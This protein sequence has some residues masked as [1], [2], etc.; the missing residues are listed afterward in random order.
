[1]ITLSHPTGNANVRAIAASL[2]RA[3]L[4]ESFHTSIATFPGNGWDKLSK[5]PGMGDIG[6]REFSA[7][8]APLTKQ[9]P[10]REVG[11]MVAGKTGIASLTAHEH[12]AF[13]VDKVY[14][15]LDEEVAKAIT[16]GRNI[17]GVYAYEDGALATFRAAK[18]VGLRC[19]YDLPIAY[20]QT[21]GK[22]MEEEAARYP[23]WAPTLSGGDGDS[24]AKLNRKTQELELADAVVGPGSFV[25][26]SLPDWAA[27]IHRIVAPFG[28]PD[29]PPPSAAQRTPAAGRRLRVLFAGSLTQRKGLA[30]LFAAMRL[31]DGSQVE[32]IVLGGLRL[33]L[34]FYKTEFG[35]FTYAPN[36]SAR[37]STGVNGKLRRFLSAFYCR[38]PRPGH[39]GGDESGATRHHHP[40]HGRCGPGNPRRDR[41]FSA[42]P[43]PR[44]DCGGHHLVFRTSGSPTAYGGCGRRARRPLHLVG[45]R[46]RRRGGHQQYN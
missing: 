17:T 3:G 10:W 18:K 39:A 35:E 9:H 44:G 6:R 15:S 4:L 32:L 1:M 34:E 43:L 5:L 24:P 12:G 7:E 16:A 38:G 13:S 30:D 26:D 8:L 14:R 20:W 37:R 23:A 27:G 36:P 42:H 19:F 41:F 45:L 2:Q 21:K 31:V 46:R 29:V 25:M 33:P 11:R 22:L 40:E 28:S